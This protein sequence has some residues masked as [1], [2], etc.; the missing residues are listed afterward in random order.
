[1][2]FTMKMLNSQKIID[3]ASL[4]IAKILVRFHKKVNFK[5]KRLQD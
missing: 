2:V 5:A 1:M 3:G 4:K